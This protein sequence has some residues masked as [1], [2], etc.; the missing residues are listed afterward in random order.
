MS[1]IAFMNNDSKQEPYWYNFDILCQHSV[2]SF[3]ESSFIKQ[4]ESTVLWASYSNISLT[5][6]NLKQMNWVEVLGFK[7]S[8]HCIDATAL[9]PPGV[10][11]VGVWAG[12]WVAGLIKATPATQTA[13]PP[14]NSTRG[15]GLNLGQ[16]L[17]HS[18]H[19]VWAWHELVVCCLR[20]GQ[21]RLFWWIFSSFTFNDLYINSLF[22]EGKEPK[23]QEPMLMSWIYNPILYS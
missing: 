13:P 1:P 12:E 14:N 9:Q 2:S 6:D 18:L 21:Q 16:W 19:A 3:P 8:L 23:S 11:R 17:G 4:L 15:R 10:W 5:D 22:I 7:Q 20:K